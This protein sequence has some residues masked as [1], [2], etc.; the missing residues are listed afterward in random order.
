MSPSV[1]LSLA[2]W[3]RHRISSRRST[4]GSLFRPVYPREDRTADPVALPAAG[5][6]AAPVGLAQ[7]PLRASYSLSIC[8]SGLL[9]GSLGE[10]YGA[11]LGPGLEATAMQ[12]EQTQRDD[13]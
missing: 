1:H 13:G 4:R 2:Y 6:L 7:R 3:L 9:D 8:R 12:G 11:G 5:A 10:V